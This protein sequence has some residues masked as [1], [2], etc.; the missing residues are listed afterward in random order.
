MPGDTSMEGVGSDV[1]SNNDDSSFDF[2]DDRLPTSGID[3]DAKQGLPA[4]YEYSSGDVA[5]LAQTAPSRP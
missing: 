4:C 3:G 2:D 1:N 5:V